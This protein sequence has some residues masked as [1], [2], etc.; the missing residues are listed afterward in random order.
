M[1][2][3]LFD[4]H[5]TVE[6]LRKATATPS[7]DLLHEITADMLGKYGPTIWSSSEP[8]LTR[9]RDEYPRYLIFDDPEDFKL[10]RAYLY[11]WILHRAILKCERSKYPSVDAM[12]TSRAFSTRNPP[13]SSMPRHTS[14]EFV[15]SDVDSSSEYEDMHTHRARHDQEV[16]T[17]TSNMHLRS[18]SNTACTESSFQIPVA[19][20]VPMASSTLTAQGA[21]DGTEVVISSTPPATLSDEVEIIDGD[22]ASSDSLAGTYSTRRIK[23]RDVSS[24]DIS[25]R[26]SQKRTKLAVEQDESRNTKKMRDN[27]RQNL[28]INME[29]VDSP[30]RLL[31]LSPQ[32]SPHHEVA[33]CN[34]PTIC[35]TQDDDDRG[36][37]LRFGPHMSPLSP[38]TYA[39]DRIGK[40]AVLDQ[41]ND[42]ETCPQG[43]STFTG[44]PTTA[45]IPGKSPSLIVVLKLS[46]KGNMNG[47]SQ[48]TPLA[49]TIQPLP[50]DCDHLTL[51]LLDLLEA[52]EAEQ[53]DF[54][55]LEETV[56]YI[57]KV[58]SDDTL[59][60]KQKFGD[61]FGQYR[62]ILDRWLRCANAFVMFHQTTK[63]S[64]SRT[65][66]PEFF[67]GLELKDKKA[68]RRAFVHTRSV[69]HEWRQEPDFT[70]TKVSKDL[71]HVLFNMTAWEGMMELDELK[72]LCTQFN[73]RLL[74]WFG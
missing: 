29:R 69:I 9:I 35:R 70:I 36:N 71:A 41:N 63:F 4:S 16:A 27:V 20:M 72:Q 25:K 74:A 11:Y 40:T 26:T 67:S 14:S 22:I 12:R 58:T 1:V 2:N 60:L 50:Y 23:R 59:Q 31:N 38:E 24:P 45:T 73:D 32:G 37:N 6:D 34:F 61:K 30:S 42:G 57:N 49:E 66:W 8:H 10:I 51:K 53:Q 47:P 44:F 65:K 52:S 15:G 46:H 7:M 43:T 48:V 5:D 18:T 17:A 56:K 19:Q 54:T 28:N 33:L 3:A 39:G 64:G 13:A 21:C 55:A 68:A 62:Q